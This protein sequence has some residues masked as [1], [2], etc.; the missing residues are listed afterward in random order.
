VPDSGAWVD[1]L[2]EIGCFD[3]DSELLCDN[4]L[5]DCFGF[6]RKAAEML[7]FAED[8]QSKFE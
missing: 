1:I 3:D 6:F 8:F 4:E 2:T 5:K 7:G